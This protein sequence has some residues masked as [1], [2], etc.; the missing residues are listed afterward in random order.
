[1]ANSL[2]I[3][4]CTYGPNSQHFLDD[5]LKSIYLQTFKEAKTYVISS[6]DYKPQINGPLD[7]IHK[8]YY[9][10]MHFPEA[11]NEGVRHGTSDRIL[12]CNDDILMQKNCVERLLKQSI[13]HPRT[14][15][16]PISNCDNSKFYSLPM[17]F[18]VDKKIGLFE[19]TQY[20][21][22][23]TEPFRDDIIESATLLPSPIE[24]NIPAIYAAF[25][26][27]MMTRK[28]WNEVGG[29]DTTLRTGQDDF[30]F[31]IRARDIGINSAIALDAFCFHYSGATA[32]LHLSKEDRMFNIDHFNKKWAHKGIQLEQLK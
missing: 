14:V 5:C 2:D 28:T 21:Y 20:K 9:S 4:V 32:D 27:T 12:L 17:G 23:D 1:M 7:V 24:G 19:S 25:Y 26:C 8:H 6:G 29:I 30:D 31:A 18:Y 15:F 13:K 10:R 11:I 3:I 22:Q 16:N